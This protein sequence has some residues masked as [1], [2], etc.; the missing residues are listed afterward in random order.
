MSGWPPNWWPVSEAPFKPG[1]RVI[2]FW[3]RKRVRPV[4]RCYPW[5][6]CASGWM[7]EVE[8]VNPPAIDS[9]KVKLAPP[10]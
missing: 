2:T 3:D 9:K 6:G 7:V 1:D 5:H 10:K 4:V 8:G